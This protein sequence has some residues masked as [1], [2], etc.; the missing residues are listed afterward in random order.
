M[1]ESECA[2]ISL[3][4]GALPKRQWL[5]TLMLAFHGLVDQVGRE[6][7]D[8]GS[9]FPGSD[10]PLVVSWFLEIERSSAELVSLRGWR[11]P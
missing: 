3:E 5:E 1:H 2:P 7:V 8:D 9:A 10:L 6:V 4:M 11:D